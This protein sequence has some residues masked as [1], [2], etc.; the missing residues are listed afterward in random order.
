[1]DRMLEYRVLSFN[2]NQ[3]VARAKEQLTVCLQVYQFR[4]G[5]LDQSG[6][7]KCLFWGLTFF[8]SEHNCMG[9]KFFWTNNFFFGSKFFFEPTIFPDQKV[10]LTRV[11]FQP[12]FCWFTLFV[13]RE[14]F[15][16]KQWNFPREAHWALD[17][18][19]VLLK[20][21]ICKI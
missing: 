1:M 12:K 15:K 14:G 4:L 9:P 21:K 18:R 6:T 3:Y 8:W 7:L 10:I 2:C 20:S 19:E 11:I 5:S 13:F 16:K 17:P